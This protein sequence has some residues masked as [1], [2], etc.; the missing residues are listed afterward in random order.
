[1]KA[2]GCWQTRPPRLPLD[3]LILH[4]DFLSIRP[5]IQ[6]DKV[7]EELKLLARL[8]RFFSFLRHRPENLQTNRMTKRKANSQPTNLPVIRLA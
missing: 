7:W 8:P 3:S 4:L 5:R 6:Q 2:V 1:M